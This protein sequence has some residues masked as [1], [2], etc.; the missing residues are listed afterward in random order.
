MSEAIERSGSDETNFESMIQID[1][2]VCLRCPDPTLLAELE[3]LLCQALDNEVSILPRSIIWR[4][5]ARLRNRWQ[6]IIAQG[7]RG[8]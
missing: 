3:I 8:L 1:F 6:L 5:R 2:V 7:G 4:C